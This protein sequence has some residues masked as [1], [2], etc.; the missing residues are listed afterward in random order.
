MDQRTKKQFQRFVNKEKSP[1]KIL[2]EKYLDR[3][4]LLSY[5]WKQLLNKSTG[6]NAIDNI[7]KYDKITTRAIKQYRMLSELSKIQKQHKKFIKQKKK[8]QAQIKQINKASKGFTT[9][10]EIEIKNNNDPFFQLHNT[11]KAIENILNEMKGLKFV[12]TL[13]VTF[14]KHDA[15]VDKENQKDEIIQDIR[16]LFYQN[17]QLTIITL[18]LLNINQ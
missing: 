17:N 10:N 8:L 4:K 16:Y 12:E 2:S 15:K 5:S 6:Q 13:V 9:S 7:E 14:E 1:L 18:I 3:A 11:R